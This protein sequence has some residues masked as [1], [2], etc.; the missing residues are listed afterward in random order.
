MEKP[1]VIID[2]IQKFYSYR[3][4]ERRLRFLEG[5]PTLVNDILG[6]VAILGPVRP[7]EILRVVGLSNESE[8][9]K[10]LRCLDFLGVIETTP[11]SQQGII[12]GGHE[13][14]SYGYIMKGH[15]SQDMSS[16][17]LPPNNALV[18]EI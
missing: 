4:I 10:V 9:F 11:I 13:T 3:A 7:P 6:C 5:N 16:H 12:S 14:I 17:F 1:K 18:Q 2:H 15:S 8:A